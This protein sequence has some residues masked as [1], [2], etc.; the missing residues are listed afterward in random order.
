MT[1]HRAPEG[2]A[3]Y[4]AGW[5]IDWMIGLFI[6]VTTALVLLLATLWVMALFGTGW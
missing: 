5:F 4:V 6:G 3:S 1:S 2:L